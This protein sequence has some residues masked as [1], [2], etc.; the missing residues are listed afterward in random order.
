MSNRA[1]CFGCKR[2]FTQKTLDLYDGKRCSRCF[3]AY[4]QKNGGQYKLKNV[5]TGLEQASQFKRYTKAQMDADEEEEEEGEVKLEEQEAK[6]HHG[7][8]SDEG[9]VV[10]SDED[11]EEEE[12]DEQEEG[13][14][15]KQT[16]TQEPKAAASS[17]H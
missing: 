1:S 10:S 4:K 11:D 5:S 7:Y 16:D 9:F 17:S 8:E 2:S 3:D 15:K 12:D 6:K 13:E 14:A